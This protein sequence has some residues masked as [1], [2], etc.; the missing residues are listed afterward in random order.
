MQVRQTSFQKMAKVRAKSVCHVVVRF[1]PRLTY[2]SISYTLELQRPTNSVEL[3]L[4]RKEKKSIPSMWCKYL[5]LCLQ[6]Y[7]FW[8]FPWVFSHETKKYMLFCVKPQ[9]SK[10]SIFY[11]LQATL[12]LTISNQQE[13]VGS[14]FKDLRVNMVLNVLEQPNQFLRSFPW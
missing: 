1:Q 11:C 6:C 13:S 2:F 4:R 7:S 9:T 14:I 12:H 8:R 3:L 10:D 5:L